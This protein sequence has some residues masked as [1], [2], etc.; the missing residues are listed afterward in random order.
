[1][2]F[3]ELTNITK[4]FDDVVAVDDVSLDIHEGEFVAILG[5]SGSGKTTTLRLL[6]GFEDA[7]EGEI[8]IDQERIS[9]Q[10]PEDRGMSLVFQDLALFPHM[11]VVENVEFGLRM[12]TDLTKEERRSAASEVLELVELEGYEERQ[13][14]ELSGGEQQRVALARAVVVEPKM[15]LFDEPLSDLDRQLR[16]NMRVEI[17]QLHNRLGITTLYVTH[18]QR[19]ALTL[20]DRIAVMNKGKVDQYDTPEN[21]YTNPN[22][23]FVAGFVGDS[24]FITGEIVASDN[25]LSIA[26]TNGSVIPISESSNVEINDNGLFFLRPE[27]LSLS[28][29]ANETDSDYMIETMTHLGST[30]EYSVNCQGNSLRVVELGRPTF[31]TGDDVSL[32]ISE[33]NKIEAKNE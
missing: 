7:T 17:A 26:G 19:E 14:G 27:H 9:E 10:P 8:S 11:T 16:E 18:N 31:S 2:V 20:A 15:L 22:S 30:T 3:A 28:E 6:A 1:M 24:N 25:A 29:P 21:I 33:I 32:S 5:P 23:K 13:I 12:Q 4:K